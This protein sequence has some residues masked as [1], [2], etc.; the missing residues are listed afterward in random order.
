MDHTHTYTHTHVHTHMYTHT[1]A[2]S[3]EFGQVFCNVGVYEVQQ[4]ASV[5]FTN[6]GLAHK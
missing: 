2:C 1:L 5:A 3:S 4:S 6:F